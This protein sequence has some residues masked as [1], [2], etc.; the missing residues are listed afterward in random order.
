MRNRS[1][2]RALSRYNATI[3]EIFEDIVRVRTTIEPCSVLFSKRFVCGDCIA[4]FILC[5]TSCM[6][7]FRLHP[8][9]WFN[10][11]YADVSD[12]FHFLCAIWPFS[13]LL[14][15]VSRWS[16]L[17]CLPVFNASHDWSIA[18]VWTFLDTN[19]SRYM[20]LSWFQNLL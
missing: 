17:T 10:I 16:L 4:W 9:D 1:A 6:S 2:S 18:S 20:W 11:K 5:A 7:S 8:I 19:I 15:I 12:A 13:C 3:I 14:I